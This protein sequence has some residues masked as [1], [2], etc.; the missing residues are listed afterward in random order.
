MLDPPADFGNRFFQTR[1]LG[2]K[3][4]ARF[5]SGE[6]VLRLVFGPVEII[7]DRFELLECDVDGAVLPPRKEQGALTVFKIPLNSSP[8]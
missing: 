3:A 7:A 5:M 8:A 4:R 6:I 1:Q 2:G